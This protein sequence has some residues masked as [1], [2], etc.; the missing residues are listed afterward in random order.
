[1]ADGGREK[2]EGSREIEEGIS[3]HLFFFRGQRVEGRAQ[4]G[5]EVDFR[6]PGRELRRGYSGLAFLQ[7]RGLSHR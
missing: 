1:M 4:W 2:G 5:P 6:S 3:I 7:V